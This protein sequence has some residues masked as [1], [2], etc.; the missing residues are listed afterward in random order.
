[1]APLAGQ[2]E[3]HQLLPRTKQ[4]K[5]LLEQALQ[6]GQA[7]W[8]GWEDEGRYASDASHIFADPGPGLVQ[9]GQVVEPLLHSAVKPCSQRDFIIGCLVGL[10][11]FAMTS[12]S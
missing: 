3:Y 1:M 7:P 8:R 9:A 2:L 10:L 5:Q 6:T 12:Q 11:A 4:T